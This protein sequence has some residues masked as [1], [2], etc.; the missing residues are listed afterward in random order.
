M[1]KKKTPVP[2]PADY[3]FSQDLT[4]QRLSRTE[5]DRVAILP[6]EEG[7][8]DPPV[9]RNPNGTFA[10]GH[11]QCGSIQKGQKQRNSV[12][13][14]NAVIAMVAEEVEKE[15]FKAGL[16]NLY[17]EDPKSYYQVLTGLMKFAA[18][19]L[20]SQTLEIQDQKQIRTIDDKLNELM[21]MTR[22]QKD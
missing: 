18:P 6:R 3:D 11:A 8:A 2:D 1:A 7:D 5:T 22:S 16:T 21:Q 4:P 14:Q 19:S 17:G 9:M 20:Q 15:R 10:K 12:R 13:V